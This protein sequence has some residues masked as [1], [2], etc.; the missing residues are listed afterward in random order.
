MVKKKSVKKANNNSLES[1]Y[2]TF[3]EFSR[4]ATIPYLEGRA[5]Q[6]FFWLKE[7]EDAL[8]ME[9]FFEMANISESSWYKFVNKSEVLK[10]V[11]NYA[12]T[13]LGK[14]R[15]K[16]GLLKRLDSTIVLRSCPQYLLRYKMQ[17]EY[18]AQLK[19]D[20]NSSS[21]SKVEI[22]LTQIP[23]TAEVTADIERKK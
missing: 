13:I 9:D 11:H 23:M 22:Q 15:E 17:Q 16:G 4:D 7:N 18:E 1:Q 3:L 20:I 14:R 6:L 5:K 19:K 12:L 21:P 8:V 10:E 2:M